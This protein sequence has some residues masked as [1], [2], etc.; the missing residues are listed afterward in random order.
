MG[1]RELELMRGEWEEQPAHGFVH[2]RPLFLS[3]RTSGAWP[4]SEAW[5]PEPPLKVLRSF[6]AVAAVAAAAAAAAAERGRGKGEDNVSMG[7]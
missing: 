5:R 3:P 4:S 7:D 1:R 2:T 6:A